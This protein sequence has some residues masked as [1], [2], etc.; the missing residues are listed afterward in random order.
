MTEKNEDTEKEK[1]D[2]KQDKEQKEKP[3]YKQRNFMIASIGIAIVLAIGIAFILPATPTGECTGAACSVNET[4]GTQI[5]N[6]SIAV[7]DYTVET[8]NGTEVDT[9]EG[10]EL[11]IG[12]KEIK[13]EIEEKLKDME[14]NETTKIENYSQIPE[15]QTQ[16]ISRTQLEKGLNTTVQ[17]GEEYETPQGTL[18]IN[19]VTNQTVLATMKNPSPYAGKTLDLVITLKDIK[20]PYE[21]IEKKE[22]PKVELFVMSQCPGGNYGE[23]TLKPI[24][25]LLG[26]SVDWNIHFILSQKNGEITSLH[27]EKEV[28]QDAREL[29]VLKNQGVG[30]WFEFATKSNKKNWETAAQEASLNSEKIK[31]CVEENKT[32]LL[33]KEAQ[34]STEKEI[35]IS[36]TVL[37]NGENVDLNSVKEAICA[38]FKNPPE[39]CNQEIQSQTTGSQGTAGSCG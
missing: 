36:P 5:E 37:V 28:M 8:S 29:C 20:E 11:K 10:L 39:E 27:G 35:T 24:H 34:I 19:K 21:D 33:Q 31:T 9:Q 16:Q 14:I 18:T 23:E 15:E 26:D 2:E 4:S 7:L 12:E 3:F 30:K 22:K 1:Q 17:E 38:G 13:P 32:Q 6:G 25:D